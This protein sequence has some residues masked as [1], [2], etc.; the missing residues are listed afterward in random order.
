MLR[1][2]WPEE[3]E[4]DAMHPESFILLCEQQWARR[5]RRR[6][7]RRWNTDE[8]QESTAVGRNVLTES[9]TAIQEEDRTRAERLAVRRVG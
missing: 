7:C 8:K 3:A 5:D 2:F 1:S 6:R 4:A 9:E